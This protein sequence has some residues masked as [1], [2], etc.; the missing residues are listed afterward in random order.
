MRKYK[1]VIFDIDGTL[2]RHNSWRSFT[3]GIGASVEDHMK[4]YGDHLSGKISLEESKRLLLKMWQATG[5]ANR[6]N[7]DRLYE[8]WFI[9][10]DAQELIDWL[11]SQQ[12]RIYL[13]TGSVGI[14]AQHIAARLGVADYISS[15][16]LYFNDAGDLVDFH[17]TA[18][19]GA[20]KLVQ[21]QDYCNHQRIQP[22]ECVPVGDGDNDIELFRVTGNGILIDHDR[23]SDRLRDTA[24]WTVKEL[25][26]IRPILEEIPHG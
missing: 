22:N 10:E 12:Y 21:M 1:A 2:T 19:Q 26:H 25:A 5:K 23:V 9:R 7:I 16:E 15:A 24:R 14:Y 13:I 18:D 6:S 4:I 8:E 20:A 17:Y 3:H 11:R